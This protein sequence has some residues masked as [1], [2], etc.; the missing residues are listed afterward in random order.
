MKKFKVLSIILGM[1]LFLVACGG[2]DSDSETTDAAKMED[3]VYFATGEVADNGW[4]PFIEITVKDGEISDVDYDAYNMH[5]GDSRTKSVRGEEGDYNLAEG[6]VAPIQE[7]FEAIEAYIVEG[8]DITAVEFDGDSKSDAI[9][10]ATISYGNIVGLYEAAMEAGP[11]ADAGD[12]EDGFYFG[13]A[14]ADD[15]GNTDQVTYIVYNGNVVAANFTSAV[16]QDDDSV[17]YKS[18]LSKKGEYSLADGAVAEMHEQLAV[19]NEELVSNNTFDVE[20]DEDGKTDA[21]SGATVS[22]DGYVAAFENAEKQ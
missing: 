7:Q 21:I 6:A 13:Q 9:S 5:D 8:N 16:P 2:S 17:A 4:M 14:E 15:K 3:G 20:F 22:V 19:L 18:I 10:G 12:M 11:V 1:S